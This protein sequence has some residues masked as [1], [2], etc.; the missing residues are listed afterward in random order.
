MFIQSLAISYALFLFFN[1]IIAIRANSA[2]KNELLQKGFNSTMIIHWVEPNEKLGANNADVF[3]DLLFDDNN[4]ASNEIIDKKPVFVH[5]VNCTC[6]EINQTN[7]IRFNA[8]NGFIN[9]SIT[10]LAC[11]DPSTKK[12]ATEIFNKLEWKFAWVNDDYGLVAARI[13][14]MIINEA[15][16][17]LEENVSTKEQIDVA[18]KLGTNYPFGPFEWSQKI[19][20]KHI[21][22][23]LKQLQKQN[24][25][26]SIS[27][28]LMQESQL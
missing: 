2:Q 19:G 15:Y 9:R 20:L 7:Y 16:Y 8:W 4:I 24:Q 17:A 25:Q 13:I 5:A 6:A 26:Y 22:N 21:A 12:I 14:A 10:E 18:M 28:L 23:L 1:M 3:F 27:E 11:S